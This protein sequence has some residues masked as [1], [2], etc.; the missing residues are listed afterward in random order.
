MTD[1]NSNERENSH[2]SDIEDYWFDALP[3]ETQ[4]EVLRPAKRK[5]YEE[6]HPTYEDKIRAKH[7]WERV[8]EREI[9][10]DIRAAKEALSDPVR[11]TYFEW[12]HCI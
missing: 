10:D 9:Q 5:A 6:A 4:E 2:R 1:P 3:N 8:E 7:D 11:I 12:R